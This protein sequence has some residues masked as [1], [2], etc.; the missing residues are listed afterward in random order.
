MLS[1]RVANVVPPGN[2][3]FFEVPETGVYLEDPEL[4]SLLTRLMRHYADNSVPCPGN[5]EELVRDFI[6]R[7]MPKGFCWGD[8][9][10]AERPK[11]YTTAD[12]RNATNDMVRRAELVTVGEAKPRAVVCGN[13]KLN[14][15][16]ACPTCTGMVAW[17]VR[18]VSGRSTGTEE[19]LGICVADGTLIPAKIFV[20]ELPDRPEYPDTCWVRG[21]KNGN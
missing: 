18:A 9:G 3:Y 19:L 17:A 11:V 12:I 21:A 6:C 20:K 8:D 15:R 14:D 4:G 1:F 5:L 10:G 13:C 7:R 2:K 16:S